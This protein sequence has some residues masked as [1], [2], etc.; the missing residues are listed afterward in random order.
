M[1]RS[2]FNTKVLAD[3]N[4][5]PVVEE[6]SDFLNV[7]YPKADNKKAIDIRIDELYVSEVTQSNKE[8]GYANVVLDII[9]NRNGSGYYRR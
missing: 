5:K 3:L 1:Q 6:L 7:C 8:T 4:K 9:E 2:L